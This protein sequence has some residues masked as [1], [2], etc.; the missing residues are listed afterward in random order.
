LASGWHVGIFEAEPVTGKYTW[1]NNT[2]CNLFGIPFNEMLEY[3]WVTG[4]ERSERVSV[5]DGWKNAI[6]KDIPYEWEY[7]VIN[8]KTKDEVKCRVTTHALR[9]LD[10][11]PLMYYGTVEVVDSEHRS[12]RG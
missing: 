11:T 8:Q 4:I 3:G 10:G 2:L 1:V 12:S 6:V 7:T 9:N 5:V